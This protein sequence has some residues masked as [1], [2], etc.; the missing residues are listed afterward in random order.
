MP[1]NYSKWDKLELSDDD[2]FE[3]HPNVDKASEIRLRQ[4]EIHRQ[5]RE[6]RIKI[7]AL[8]G[9][10]TLIAYTAS[11]L[12]NL[13]TSQPPESLVTELTALRTTLIDKANELSSNTWKEANTE[14]DY[15]WGP[16]EPDAMVQD[17]H[18]FGPDLDLLILVA[19]KSG[20]VASLIKKLLDNQAERNV[21][22]KEEVVRLEKEEGA[23]MTSENMYK[24][25]F[26]KT[27]VSKESDPNLKGKE[28]APAKTA[29]QT[30][31][32]TLNSKAA[33]AAEESSKS[34]PSSTST[35]P[36][37]VEAGEEDF[38]TNSTAAAFAELSTM[39]ES[40]RFLMS[41]MSIV[42]DDNSD[43]ILA[44]AMREEMAGNPRKARQCVAQSLILQYCAKLGRDGVRLFFERL[45]TSTH[46]ARDLYMND[47]TATYQRIANRV[48][49]IQKESEEKE[50]A[51]AEARIA[52]ALQPDGS[53]ALPEDATASE[54]YR[55]RAEVFA[56]L[57]REFQR[58][59][60]SQDADQ[61]NQVM[62]TLPK[63][64]VEDMV[65][66]CVNCGLL[67][68]DDGEE[69]EA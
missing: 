28:T 30:V 14:R 7:D 36:Q 6:R 67:D 59:L 49:E 17:M 40:Y 41:N 21:V 2:D 10:S 13:N 51:A 4:A 38:I 69:E 47:V 33:A 61:I 45:K 44:E 3:G 52:A 23:K 9:E 27:I 24:E 48:K 26:N 18:P 54:Y 68:M 11:Q 34:Q 50:Q 32:A 66:R 53:Y 60:L 55:V 62:S 19:S 65:D 58:A 39:E 1:I 42:T 46:G 15:R 20:D 64:Q 16:Y 8:K 5:R 43:E 22:I 57:P 56:S 31:I 12:L 25:G 63:Q 29:T 37:A 35:P